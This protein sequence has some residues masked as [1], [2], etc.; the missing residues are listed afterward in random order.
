MANKEQWIEVELKYIIFRN[1]DNGFSVLSTKLIDAEHKDSLDLVLRP[2]V[3][4]SFLTAN[5][6]DKLK[7]TGRWGKNRQGKTQ[8]EASYSS[9]VVP[10]TSNSIME[11]LMRTVSGIGKKRAK[12]IVS[13]FGDETIDIIRETPNKLLDIDGIG[14]KSASNIYEQLVGNEVYEDLSMYLISLGVKQADI[15]IIYDKYGEGALNR[16]RSNPY[17]LYMESNISFRTLDNIANKIDIAFNNYNRISTGLEHFVRMRM[18]NYGDLYVTKDLIFDQFNSFL[19]RVGSYN[20]NID[21]EDIEKVIEKKL[22]DKSFAIEENKDKEDCIYLG[23]YNYV[24]NSIVSKIKER[25]NNRSPIIS[26]IEIFKAIESY[27]RSTGMELAIL[28]KQG[29]LMAIQNSISIISGGPG[30]GKTQVINSIIYALKRIKPGT[31]I[32]LAAPTGKAAKRMTELTGMEAKTIHRLIGLKEFSEGGE[33]LEGVYADVLVIDESSMIDAYLFHKLLTAVSDDTTIIM[34]GDHE[35]LPSVGPGL[36]LRDLIDSK[37]IPTVRL[38]EIFRQEEGSNIIHNAHEIVNG[39]KNLKFSQN[40]D[41]DFYFIKRQKERSIKETIM[42]SVENMINNRG[43]KIEDIQV[44]SSMNKGELGTIS[45]NAE[46]QQRFNKNVGGVQVGDRI[47]K[48]D[49]KVMQTVNNYDFDVFNGDSGIVLE[50]YGKGKDRFVIVEYDDKEIEYTDEMLL[51]LTHSYAMT[52]HKS[53]GSEYPVI[54]MP[55]HNSLN[56]LLYRNLINTG[57]T[58]ARDV[59]VCIGELGELERGIDKI[60]NLNRNSLIKEKLVS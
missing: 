18:G 12:D 42:I 2:V 51:E 24:E 43:Y 10:E 55:F 44:L 46:L 38:T 13:K 21:K 6:G 25:I 17:S 20:K 48:K 56:I 23:Y 33:E 47:F 15:N 32:E 27:E 36:I 50:A 22:E 8:F 1:N 52:V 59:V 7:V 16:I 26:D 54:I 31:I 37:Q 3:V 35:Q 49:D 4:G 11:Y 29:V 19:R 53:Q 14:P 60:N 45:L 58:R 28:Q 34:V 9:V 5:V 39:K 41:G 30:T 40:G 57:I